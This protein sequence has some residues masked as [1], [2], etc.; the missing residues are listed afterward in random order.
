MLMALVCVIFAVWFTYDGW[1]NKEYQ[2]KET[3]DGKP[4]ANLLFNRY[5]PIPL[6]IMAGYFLLAAKK[7]PKFRIV[8]DENGLSIDGG[9][10]IPYKAITQIDKRYFE[11]EGHLS[12]IYT[13]NDTEKKLKLTD[14]RY[15]N[16]GMVLDELVRR[17]G[18]QPAQNSEND[19]ETLG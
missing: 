7:A 12:L 15:D 8:A 3:K 13:E 2:E 14:R 6:A 5:V 10:T 1:I 9:R 18:A 16:L 19:N 4:S 17:T 11:K